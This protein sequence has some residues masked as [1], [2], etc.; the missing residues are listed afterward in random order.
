M[1]TDGPTMLFPLPVLPENFKKRLFI[2]LQTVIAVKRLFEINHVCRVRSKHNFAEALAR[3]ET[4]SA[5]LDT[6]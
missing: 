6:D 4:K 3:P 2:R 1:T 5:L